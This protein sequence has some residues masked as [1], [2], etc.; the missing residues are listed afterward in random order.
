MPGTWSGQ[1]TRQARSRE[2]VGGGGRFKLPKNDGDLS[3]R[4]RRN[5]T[6][7]EP[8]PPGQMTHHVI[9]PLQRHIVRHMLPFDD[10]REKLV[11]L[12]ARWESIPFAVSWGVMIVRDS[13]FSVWCSVLFYAILRLVH[14][15]IPS[16]QHPQIHRGEVCRGRS[17]IRAGS[18]REGEV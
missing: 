18:G 17:R 6:F 11:H 8:L 5:D 12:P 14:S 1:R 7:A 2:V 16:K 13:V 4:G 10:L 15:F 9:V 3:V